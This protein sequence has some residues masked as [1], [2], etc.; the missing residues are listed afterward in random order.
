MEKTSKVH[1]VN[2]YALFIGDE[3]L[4]EL[5]Y[6]QIRYTLSQHSFPKTNKCFSSCYYHV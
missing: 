5:S 3:E 6:G 4:E 1:T 2:D